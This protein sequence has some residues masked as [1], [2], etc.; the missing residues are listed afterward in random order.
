MTNVVHLEK[1]RSRIYLYADQYTQRMKQGN[2]LA[3]GQYLAAHVPPQLREQVKR[4]ADAMVRE[5][6]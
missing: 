1:S 6:G 3:A 4:A 2:W 5:E